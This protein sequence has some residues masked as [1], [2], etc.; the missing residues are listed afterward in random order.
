MA[1]KRPKPPAA[2]AEDPGPI[3]PYVPVSGVI[4]AHL[5]SADRRLS[6]ITPAIPPSR[7][8]RESAAGSG[9]ELGDRL[10]RL[11]DAVALLSDLLYRVDQVHD[12][13]L[14]AR[15]LDQF[16][17]EATAPEP[18]PVMIQSLAG[19]LDRIAQEVKS[20][21]GELAPGREPAKPGPLRASNDT[22][23]FFE[24]S[25]TKEGLIEAA[26]A[27]VG[28]VKIV[29]PLLGMFGLRLGPSPARAPGGTRLGTVD[30][31]ALVWV[32]WQGAVLQALCQSPGEVSVEDVCGRLAALDLGEVP[33][34]DEIFGI[35]KYVAA[36]PRNKVTRRNKRFKRDCR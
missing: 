21:A 30:T 8:A 23:G 18:S 28:V 3:T 14:L 31:R 36:Q 16:I 32:D 9:D 13:A 17:V 12:A 15:R 35:L 19:D 1:K 34:D 26:E 7:P 27:V 33:T 20:A 2:R 4:A 24:L 6:L 5:L 10:R 11:R 25:V 29:V 22:R